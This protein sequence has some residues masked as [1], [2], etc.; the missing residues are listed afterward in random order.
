VKKPTGGEIR[1]TGRR[2]ATDKLPV[3]PGHRLSVSQSGIRGEVDVFLARQRPQAG[4]EGL[5]ADIG[6]GSNAACARAGQLR[7]FTLIE[8]LG[9]VAIIVVIVG[10]AGAQLVR[11]PGDV[12]R[13]ESEHSRCSCGA[14][15]QEAIRRDGCSLSAP[16]EVVPLFCAW[17]GN[18]P[19]VTSGD[20]LLRPPAPGGGI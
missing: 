15:R 18:G 7:G 11:G 13:E 19:S 5:D 12:V 16:G 8:L 6:C 2:A 1:E 9:V 14:A 4:G 17:S 10:L 20:E 3:I